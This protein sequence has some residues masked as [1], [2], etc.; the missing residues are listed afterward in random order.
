M[1]RDKTIAE[2]EAELDLK[3]V[4]V[5]IVEDSPEFMAKKKAYC[6]ELGLRCADNC[7]NR[8]CKMNPNYVSN[9]PVVQ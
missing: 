6:S 9:D 5:P 2:A 1:S 8:H 3:E 7:G 4:H